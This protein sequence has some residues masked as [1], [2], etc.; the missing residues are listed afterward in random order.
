[1]KTTGEDLDLTLDVGEVGDLDKGIEVDFWNE[2]T[3]AGE[4]VIPNEN[5]DDEEAENPFLNIGKPVAATPWDKA[6]ISFG[7]TNW[8]NRYVRQKINPVVYASGVNYS[9]GSGSTFGW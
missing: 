9:N 8:S 2:N 3:E 5:T 7:R 1:M 6:A 4:P